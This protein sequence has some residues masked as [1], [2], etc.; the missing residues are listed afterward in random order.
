MRLNTFRIQ[1]H[2][3]FPSRKARK[4]NP[5]HS[6]DNGT[7]TFKEG[8]SDYASVNPQ[9]FHP[10]FTSKQLALS[11]RATTL[12]IPVLRG[13][14]I[15]DA[16]KLHSDIQS[17]LREDPISAEHLDKQSDP[18]TLN[19]DWFTKELW[20][21]SMFWTPEVFGLCVLQ[22]STTIPLQDISVRQRHYIKFGCTITG[23]DFR[24]LSKD[25]CNHVPF[26]PCQPVCHK[27]LRILKQLPIPAKPWNSISMD[28]IEKLTPYSS[29]TSILVIVDHLSKQSLFISGLMTPLRLN[30]SVQLFILHIFSQAWRSKPRHFQSWHGICIPFLPVLGTALDMKFHFTSGYHPGR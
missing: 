1:P 14:L 29:Y 16:E 20:T 24:F 25:Y 5:M 10:V 17:Q 26:V 12:S 22:Y 7:S 13:S 2:H 8:N 23:L 6:L 9:N 4:P 30:N 11:L 3:S 19:P 15:M 21:K 28:F 18:W 27:T